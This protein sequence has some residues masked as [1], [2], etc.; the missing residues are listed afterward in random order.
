MSEVYKAQVSGNV[1][2]TPARIK[3][4]QELIDDGAHEAEAI[5]VVIAEA[6]QMPAAKRYLARSHGRKG[7]PVA[8]ETKRKK[9]QPTQSKPRD[10]RK[11][12]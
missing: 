5:A 3:R 9:R 8:A 11:R 1:D 7:A 2:L 4:M 10:S 12:S 6:S